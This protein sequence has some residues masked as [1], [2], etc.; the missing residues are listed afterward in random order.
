MWSGIQVFYGSL[1][2]TRK[3]LLFTFFLS[4]MLKGTIFFLNSNS[5]VN[6]D[7][8]TYI[9]AAQEFT[10]GNFTGALAIHPLALYPLLISLVHCFT[11]D[12]VTAARLIS[13]M[14][15]LL[16]LIPLY[17]LAEDLYDRRVAFW[18]CLSFSFSP[19]P[20]RLCLQV[21][22]EPLFAL[23]FAAFCF[24]A[25]RAIV[26]KK[27]P[28]LIGA[29][30]AA[31]LAV[32]CRPEGA[33]VLPIYLIFLI[34]LAISKPSE[35]KTFLK[36][37]FT[38]IM[39]MI[40]FLGIIMAA[41]FI[42]HS[43]IREGN[44]YIGYLR[45]FFK[46]N[47]LENYYRICTQ[48]AQMQKFSPHDTAGWNFSEIANRSVPLIYLIGMMKGLIKVT[49]VSNIVAL[50]L[51]LKRF[52]FSRTHLLILFLALSYFAMIYCFVIY[53][54]M[55]DT[56][57]FLAPA[58]V[59]YPWIGMGIRKTL[60]ELSQL[61]Y[62]KIMAAGAALLFIITPLTKSNHLFIKPND[63]VIQA[64]EWL[65]DQPEL[66]AS[67]IMST[68]DRVLFYACREGFCLT[69]YI[70]CRKTFTVDYECLEKEAN[71]I[72]VDTL[73]IFEDLE[74]RTAPDHI[75]GYTK[76]K[77][78]IDPKKAIFIYLTV[79]PSDKHITQPE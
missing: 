31:F 35:R 4:A 45:D 39:S 17:F 44:Q 61:S 47:F 13:F 73:I 5:A 10:K 15:L 25:Q 30:A 59:L 6:H 50:F 68:D 54:D 34:G 72:G 8:L 38:W 27:M 71:K 22:R 14:S 1:L 18:S 60:T 58:V 42:G 77:E 51:G 67:K 52:I 37:I 24:L 7:A 33:I 79:A 74:N 75:R 11:P 63:V 19:E 21:L 70:V 69:N 46:M 41:A 62:G 49:F 23:M 16:M 65:A 9:A 36:F 56:R 48:L 55:F 57:F 76:A 64:G 78:F 28:H 29:A 3:G 53:T 66:K 40:V 43:F 32:L 26:S 20:V 12:W 2:E